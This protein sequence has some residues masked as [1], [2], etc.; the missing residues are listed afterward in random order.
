[1]KFTH[2]TFMVL[3]G[4]SAIALDFFAQID[5]DKAP[6]RGIYASMSRRM[7]PATPRDATMPAD[8]QLVLEMDIKH[9]RSNIR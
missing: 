8:L 7:G 3:L 1:M 2:T 5:Q 9:D 4:A 6:L